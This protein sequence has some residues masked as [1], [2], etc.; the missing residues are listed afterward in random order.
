MPLI[1]RIG[2]I[3][4]IVIELLILFSRVFQ[5]RSFSMK[6]SI[7]I[8]SFMLICI[9][10][11]SGTVF[12]APKILT[13]DYFSSPEGTAKNWVVDRYKPED[14]DISGGYLYLSVG[15]TGYSKTRPM[16][17]Q[18]K[19]YALQGKKLAAQ[20]PT[21]TTWT[22]TIK[23]NIDSAWQFS[24]GNQKKVTFSVYLVDGSGKELSDIPTISVLKAGGNPYVNFYNPAVKDSWPVART[25]INGDGEKEELIVEEGWHTLLIKC[26]KGTLT[27]YLDG[28][29][30]GNCTIKDKDVY[31]SYMAINAYNY[32]FPDV[33][34]WDDCILYN[35]SYQIPLLSREK[36]AAKDERLAEKYEAKRQRWIERYTQ[37]QFGANWYTRAQAE[38]K[39]LDISD[40]SSSKLTKEIP[41]SYYNY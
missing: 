4:L 40:A 11:F 23:L 36:Q 13:R 15:R 22:A 32:G 12:A 38:E 3:I 18:D 21:S 25:F 17:K 6:K 29:K 16:D 27:Y 34:C 41:D 39:G 26:T 35:G 9:T 20:K 7:R 37:Y 28:M 1:F 8:I 2:T 14:F 30:L 10:I 5:R 19:Y 33:T 24:D 31:P